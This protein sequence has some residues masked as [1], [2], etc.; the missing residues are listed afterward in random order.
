[1]REPPLWYGT[2]FIS[3]PCEDTTGKC[4]LQTGNPALTSSQIPQCLDLGLASLQNGEPLMLVK[5]PG[6]RSSKAPICR[7]Q[8]QDPHWMPKTTESTEPCNLMPFSS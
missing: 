2:D 1:M 8:V 4:H 5:L 7:G 6:L 3:Q